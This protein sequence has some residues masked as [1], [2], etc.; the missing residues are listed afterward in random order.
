[1]VLGNLKGQVVLAVVEVTLFR[2]KYM[3]TH[4]CL[5]RLQLPI[6]KMFTCS[7]SVAARKSRGLSSWL[8]QVR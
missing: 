7:L 6:P 5:T 2:T 1:M 3:K 8:P 4:I